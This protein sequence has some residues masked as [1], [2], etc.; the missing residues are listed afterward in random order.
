M[1]I[2]DLLKKDIRIFGKSKSAIILSYLVPMVITLIF[3]A[4]FG[5]FGED[6][7]GINGIKVLVT[8]NDKTGFSKNFIENVDALEEITVYRKY[9]VSDDVHMPFTQEKM[10]EYIIKGNYPVGILIEKGFE[11]KVKNKQPLALKIHYDPK[12]PIEHGIVVGMMQK[13]IPTKYP[14]LMMNGL[15]N[16]SEEYLG[17]QDNENFKSNMMDVV[18]QYFPEAKE[19]S[20]DSLMVMSDVKTE[21]SEG[22]EGQSSMFDKLMDI[23]SVE[24]LGKKVKN[25]MFAQYVAGMAI[26]FLLLQLAAQP[27]PCLKKRKMGL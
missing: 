27:V 5:G 11:E 13:L 8:D 12:Y 10:D 6:D 22:G 2:L 1:R 3:G 21:A 15:W 16:S 18:K 4:I 9:V 7:G 14:Q 23:E 24:L 26:M 25:K 17:E 19:I 20:L